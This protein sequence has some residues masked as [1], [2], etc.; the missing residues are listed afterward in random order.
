MIPFGSSP[1]FTLFKTPEGSNFEGSFKF[2][3]DGLPYITSNNTLTG[4][5]NTWEDGLPQVFNLPN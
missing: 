3:V 4:G 2:W 5:L 1:L